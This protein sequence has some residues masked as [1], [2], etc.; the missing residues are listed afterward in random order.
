MA[1]ESAETLLTRLLSMNEEK[2]ITREKFL[3]LSSSLDIPTEELDIIFNALDLN[4]DGVISLEEVR[5]SFADTRIREREEEDQ[6]P[7]GGVS[8]QRR[9][10]VA[11][12]RRS[13][14]AA[15]MMGLDFSS[16]SSTWWVF[17]TEMVGFLKFEHVHVFLFFLCTLY[18]SLPK[19]FNRSW[20]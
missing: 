1:C 18:I 14:V 17:I 15:L 16:L 3:A 10:D 20:R 5:H 6:M 19:T 13:S 11:R 9:M 8:L 12:K 7:E 2:F 4:G